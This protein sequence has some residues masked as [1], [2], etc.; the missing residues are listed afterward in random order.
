LTVSPPPVQAPRIAPPQKASPII[1]ALLGGAAGGLAFGPVGAVV[2]AA[3][4]GL[5]T[6]MK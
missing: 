4:A 6:A 5:V 2:G 3:A 1:P